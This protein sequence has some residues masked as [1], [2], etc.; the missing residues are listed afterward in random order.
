MLKLED[1]P[2]EPVSA[3]NAILVYMMSKTA[4]GGAQIGKLKQSNHHLYSELLSGSLVAKSAASRIDDIEVAQSIKESLLL[5]DELNLQQYNSRLTQALSLVLALQF[6]DHFIDQESVEIFDRAE[7][8][9]SEKQEI[10]SLMAEAR[11]VVDS[12]ETLFESQKKNVL[13]H[14]AKIEN[15]LHKSK[16]NFQAFLAAA[17]E[18]SGL[19]R[20]VGEDAQPIA[21]A[22]E[23][24]RTITQKKVV[25]YAQLPQDEKPKQ[26]PKP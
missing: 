11:K 21:D 2:K 19:V 10:R 23:K 22:V 3:L 8:S 24:A 26:L 25:G 6:D 15:E 12:S 14:I 9:Q 7:L 5:K 17:Y 18:M 13:F 16:S 1:L 4:N 20:Q